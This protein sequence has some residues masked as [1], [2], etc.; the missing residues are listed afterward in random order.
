MLLTDVIMPVMSGRE[1]YEQIALL[2]PAIKTLYIS[3][4]TDGK[5]DETGNLPDGVDYLQKPFTPDALAAKVAR[6]LDQG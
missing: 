5:I 6:I 2:R 3:G 1:L 4:Y